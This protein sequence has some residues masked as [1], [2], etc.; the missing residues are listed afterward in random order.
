MLSVSLHLA[1][2]THARR[3]PVACS[4]PVCR[5]TSCCMTSL[6]SSAACQTAVWFASLSFC[7]LAHRRFEMYHTHAYLFEVWAMARRTVFVVL[8]SVKCTCLAIAADL[9]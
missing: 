1:G 7:F 6:H 9:C 4:M 2:N 3:L 8:V 5:L